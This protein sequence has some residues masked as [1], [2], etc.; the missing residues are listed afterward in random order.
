LSRSASG[1]RKLWS[2]GASWKPN[3]PDVFGAIFGSNWHVWTQRSI[4][5]GKPA[6]SGES[7]G[8]GGDRFR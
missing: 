2:G 1:V 5:G 3:D 7:F 4:Q 8:E 6:L